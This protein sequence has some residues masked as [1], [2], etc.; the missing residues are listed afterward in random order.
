MKKIYNGSAIIPVDRVASRVIGEGSHHQPK[1]KFS[2]LHW[3]APP[4]IRPKPKGLRV[5]LT[6]KT[7]GRFTV[8]G[9]LAGVENQWVVRCACGDYEIRRAK[10]INNPKN[11]RDCCENCRHLLHLKRQQEYLLTGRRLD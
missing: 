7:F 3:E 4:S 8:L 2:V 11:N 9:V 10:A 1:K 5:D 6:G